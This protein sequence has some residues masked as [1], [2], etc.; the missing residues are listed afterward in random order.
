MSGL[1]TIIN[2]AESISFNRRRM[3]GIQYTRSQI[4]RT[5]ETPTRNPWRMNVK[6]SRPFQYA[7]ARALIEQIDHSDRNTPE[8]ITFSNNP[9]LSYLCA[10]QGALNKTQLSA[11]AVNSFTGNQLVL[12]NLTTIPVGSVMFKA[13]DF[14]QIGEGVNYPYPF[15]VVNNVVRTVDN[16][17]T[18]TVHRGNFISDSVVGQPIQVGNSV[19]WAMLCVNMPTYTMTRGGTTALINFDTDFQLYEYTGTQV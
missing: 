17:V 11:L 15:T 16:T 4:A 18:V 1:Q 6:V 3:I 13:G 7:D 9:N 12:T 19:S 14:I 5:G 8:I 10:Y 2:S